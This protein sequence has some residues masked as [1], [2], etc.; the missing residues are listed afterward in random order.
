MNGVKY[1]SAMT[2]TQVLNLLK[3]QKDFEI[4]DYKGG[5]YGW[6]YNNGTPINPF[7]IETKVATLHF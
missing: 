6:N 4:R 7:P 5:R 3:F 1:N 2:Q